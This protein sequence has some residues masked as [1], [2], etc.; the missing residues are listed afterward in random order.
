MRKDTRGL[1]SESD[2]WTGGAVSINSNRRRRDRSCKNRQEL[3]TLADLNQKKSIC[4][5]VEHDADT[6]D[7]FA[8]LWLC[9]DAS[10]PQC[11]SV[12]LESSRNSA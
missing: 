4:S 11:T 5:G 12:I 8:G 2:G 6:R 1:K 10:E 7:G 9:T 3:A